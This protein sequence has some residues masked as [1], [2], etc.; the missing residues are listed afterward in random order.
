[1]SGGG[2]VGAADCCVD[3]GFDMSLVTSLVDSSERSIARIVGRG[4]AARM[5]YTAL[6]SVWGIGC[7]AALLE[8]RG[9]GLKRILLVKQAS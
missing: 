2:S 3:H 4:F 5:P 7:V 9:P 1:M 6:R 8:L